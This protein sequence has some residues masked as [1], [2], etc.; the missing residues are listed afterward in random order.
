MDVKLCKPFGNG[1]EVICRLQAAGSF[2]RRYGAYIKEYTP[3]DYLVEFTLKDDQRQDP[4]ITEDSLIA[5]KILDQKQYDVLEKYTVAITQALK[6]CLSDLDLE[7]I[8]IKYEY[9]IADGGIVL[10][11]EIS[12]GSMRV[13]QDG[14]IL[15]P[16]TLSNIILKAHNL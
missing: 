1:L 5:L 11:D 12:A 8:D 7:L 6:S 3:L 16:I 15:D 2:I 9:G 14:K 13:S 4:L 10:M